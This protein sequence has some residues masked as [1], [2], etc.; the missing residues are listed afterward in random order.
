[1]AETNAK[2][3]EEE[4]RSL[5]EQITLRIEMESPEWSFL[6]YRARAEMIATEVFGKDSPWEWRIMEALGVLPH[7]VIMQYDP[8]KVITDDQ[9]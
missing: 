8:R 7:V 4:A 6:E 9:F 5:T 3:L 2:R 1:M